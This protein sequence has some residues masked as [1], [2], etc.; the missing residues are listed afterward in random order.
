MEETTSGLE[1]FRTGIWWPLNLLL[2][3]LAYLYLWDGLYIPHIGDE[4]PYIEITRLTAESGRLLPLRSAPGLENTKPP[5]LFWMGVFSTGWAE[6][7]TLARLRLPLILFTFLTA[8]VV[9]L[10]TRRLA[11][12][13]SAFIAALSF[14]GFFTTFRYGRSFLTN[15]PETFFVFLPIALYVHLGEARD[16]F[17]WWYWIAAGLSL[18]VA[19]LFKSFVLVLPAGLAL[20]WMGLA[21]RDWRIPDF[22]VRD[23]VPLSAAIAIALA[24]FA[25]W[26]AFDPDPGLVLQRFVLEENLQKIGVPAAR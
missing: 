17:R 14:L 8:A 6:H 10:L 19:C 9:F 24:C 16:R 20:A 11:G 7:F 15:L 25:L 1:P 26:P 22:V 21:E 4:P 5:L 2:A 12:R 18:G 13:E 3:L 23:A